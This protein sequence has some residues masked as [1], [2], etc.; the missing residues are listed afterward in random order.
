M[1]I[2]IEP[3]AKRE[4]KKLL[5]KDVSMI[6]KKIFTIKD[7]PLDH[8]ERLKGLKLWKLRIGDYRAIMY[9]NTGKENIHILKIGHRKNIYKR[10]K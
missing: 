3:N 7:N 4:L 9:V 1:N 5:Q 8:I 6:L 2:I 10:L